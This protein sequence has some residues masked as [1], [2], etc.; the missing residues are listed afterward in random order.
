[1]RLLQNVESHLKKLFALNN[2][3]GILEANMNI[4]FILC[5]LLFSIELKHIYKL[6][7]EDLPAIKVRALLLMPSTI[8]DV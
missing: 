3:I 2:L 8:A 7:I 4:G 5:M 1:M 6:F